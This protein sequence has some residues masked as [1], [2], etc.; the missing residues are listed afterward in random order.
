MSYYPDG[1][2]EIMPESDFVLVDRCF[3]AGDFVK[4]SIDDVRSG[5]VERISVKAKL[6]HVISGEMVDGWKTIEDVDP[7]GEIDVGDYVV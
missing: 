6:A 4:R 1:K 7:T 5:I 2:R 3:Q